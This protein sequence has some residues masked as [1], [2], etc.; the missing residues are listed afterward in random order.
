MLVA[1]L[2]QQE[3][4]LRAVGRELRARDAAIEVGRQNLRRAALDWHE[5]DVV[6]RA[7]DVLRIAALCV[8]DRFC[9]PD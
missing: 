6:H 4:D 5:R 2:F 1:A 3:Q 9:Y 8:D 7:P